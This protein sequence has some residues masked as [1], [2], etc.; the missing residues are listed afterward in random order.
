MLIAIKLHG[1]ANGILKLCYIAVL[2]KNKAAVAFIDFIA[3]VVAATLVTVVACANLVALNVVVIINAIFI[4]NFDLTVMSRAE[5][6]Y[7]LWL[8]FS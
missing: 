6:V 1:F 4:H 3:E 2:V 8:P 7:K 5:M